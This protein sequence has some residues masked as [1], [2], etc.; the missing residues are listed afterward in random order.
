MKSKYKFK[1]KKIE[2]Q[3]VFNEVNCQINKHY[4]IQ[5]QEELQFE[6]I[7][8]KKNNAWFDELCQI[9]NVNIFIN[10]NDKNKTEL[11]IQLAMN[12]Q[13]KYDFLIVLSEGSD[14]FDYIPKHKNFEF[15]DRNDDIFNEPLEIYKNDM[16]KFIERILKIRNNCLYKEININNKQ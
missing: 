14:V 3:Y 11:N 4:K 8:E 15:V 16:W 5:N 7:S 1:V 6:F 12:E 13:L 2:S 9:G 10:Q